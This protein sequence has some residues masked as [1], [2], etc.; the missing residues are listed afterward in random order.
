[1]VVARI[2][3]SLWAITFVYWIVLAFGNKQT[4]IRQSRASRL[5][6]VIAL[7]AAVE[8][9]KAQR[10]LHFLLLP[11]NAATES[12]GLLLCV[13]GLALAIQARHILGRNWS[14]FVSI[15]QDHELIQRG[16]YRF[17]RHPLY[18][19]LIVALTGTTLSLAP[20]AE[21]FLLDLVLIAAF[22]VKARQEENVLAGEFG[23]NYAEYKRSVKAALIPFVL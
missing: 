17:V 22:Y 16:P 4:K 5:A 7:V 8:F 21:G 10:G 9:L 23:E 1:M 19:G 3:G 13:A 2:I 11:A 14:G 6:Y 20:T 15:K 18:T 12:A